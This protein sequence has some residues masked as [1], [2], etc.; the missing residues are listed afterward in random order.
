MK[1]V[2]KS[3]IAAYHPPF[4]HLSAQLIRKLIPFECDEYEVEM[5]A[6]EGIRQCDSIDETQFMDELRPGT[7]LMHGQ[8]VIRDFLNSGGFGNTYLASDSLERL[9]VIKECFP[10]AFCRR[11][12]ATVQPRSR[13]HQAEFRSIV[14]FFA[15][16]ARSLAKV[17][18]PNIVGVHNVFEENNTAYMALDF[19]N[20]RDL[21]D[22]IEDPNAKPTPAQI[23]GC[24]EKML[25]AIGFVHGRG[26]LHRDVS[27]DNIIVRQDGEPILIDFGAARERATGE[28]QVLSAPRLVKDGYSPQEFYIAGSEQGPSCDLYSLAASFY[29]LITGER[30]PDSQTRLSAFAAGDPDPYVPLAKRTTD[31]DAN[32]CA[33][34][35]QAMSLIPKERLQSSEIWLKA[36]RGTATTAA[37]A[38][39]K[40]GVEPRGVKVGPAPTQTVGGVKLIFV[41]TAMVAVAGAAIFFYPPVPKWSAAISIQSTMPQLAAQAEPRG[42][43]QRPAPVLPVARIQS[44]VMPAAEAVPEPSPAL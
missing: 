36:I 17:G 34:L 2:L 43:G 35:D 27:P 32:F 33:A 44:P 20:G 15:Q 1:T 40:A 24:L 3:P 29:H 22:I 5:A 7:K 23:R 4:C 14:R 31:F 37:P 13:A 21:L 30:P 12:N 38:A 9:V 10:G 11:S 26:M 18:H 19:V 6:P 28:C 16:E 39:G 41:T 25:D 42:A 8:Y